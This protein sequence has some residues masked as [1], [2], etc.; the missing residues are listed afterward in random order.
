METRSISEVMALEILEYVS[1]RA[2]VRM[3][4]MNRP[5]GCDMVAPS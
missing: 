1:Q 5:Q 2:Q 4:H 3:Q